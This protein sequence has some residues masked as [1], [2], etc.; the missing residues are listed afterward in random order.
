M[1]HLVF[2]IMLFAFAA[3]MSAQE[4]IKDDFESGGFGGPVI[5]FTSINNQ[6]ALMLGGRGGWIINH[7]LVL[8]G[9]IYGVVNEI[10]APEGVLPLEGP[11]DIEFGY[12]GFEVEYIFHPMSLF[13]FSIYTLIGGGATNFV[14][15]VGPVTES[16]E[17]AG[18]SHFMFVLEPAIG[19][20]LN[21]TTWFHLNGGVSY[22]VTGGVNQVGLNDR[23]FSNIAATL[24]FKFGKF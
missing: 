12:L 20:E 14:K 19:A 7:S 9:G 17:Q 10:N 18:E 11:L 13:H 1:R 4:L 5:K 2:V 22:R 23:D 15:D 6:S 16:N 8:G 21:I 3:N 24:T